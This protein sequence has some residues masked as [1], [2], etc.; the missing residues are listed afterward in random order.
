MEHAKSAAYEAVSG[1]SNF[2]VM[3]QNQ[4][5]HGLGRVPRPEPI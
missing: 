5:C 1:V 4:G 2:T 3:K